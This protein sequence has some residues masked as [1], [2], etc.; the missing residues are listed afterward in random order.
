[1]EVPQSSVIVVAFKKT[2]GLVHRG[3]EKLELWRTS[4]TGPIGYGQIEIE[5]LSI[6]E[7]VW[8]LIHFPET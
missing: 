1:M 3:H 4:S 5:A 7:E 2:P 8:A 6:D